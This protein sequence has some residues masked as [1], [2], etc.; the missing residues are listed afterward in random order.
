MKKL[1]FFII[2]TLCLCTVAVA[3]PFTD[4]MSKCIVKKTTESDKAMFIR[5]IY[6]AMSSHPDVEALS[7]ISPEKRDQLNQEAASLIVE[8]LTV[9]CKDESKQAVKYEGG[10]SFKAGFEQLG[11]VAMQG[12]MSHPDVK[13]Y[14]SGLESYMDAEKLKKTFVQEQ[15]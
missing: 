11:R 8:L 6:V 13:E 3:G 4:E 7:N 15:Q 9:R 2:A 12:L 1:G 5:W 10:D 14:L